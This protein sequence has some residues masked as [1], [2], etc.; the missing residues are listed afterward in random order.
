MYILNWGGG[1]VKNHTSVQPGGSWPTYVFWL[2]LRHL[3]QPGGFMPKLQFLAWYEAS[4]PTWDISPNFWV[5]A[6]WLV[7]QPGASCPS[8]GISPGIRLYAQP[9]AS[10]PTWGSLPCGF[11]HNLGLVEQ[12]RCF[13]LFWIIHPGASCLIQDFLTRGLFLVQH[14]SIWGFFPNLGL[15]AWSRTMDLRRLT[16][17]SNHIHS[18][19]SFSTSLFMLISL[20]AC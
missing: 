17:I 10:Y 9:G 3:V 18:F 5:L 11:S 7:T 2:D 16:N 1:G 15:L 20:V 19:I 14:G 13:F 12:C 6:L 8:W 4:F